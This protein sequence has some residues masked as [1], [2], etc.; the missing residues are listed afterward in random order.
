MRPLERIQLLVGIAVLAT[1]VGCGGG[2]SS[3]GA[4]TA[5][6][7]A[8]AKAAKLKREEEIVARIPGGPDP[9]AV[10]LLNRV[11]GFGML[12]VDLAHKTLYRFGEDVRGSG[13]THCY[14][15]CTKVWYPKAS[16]EPPASGS[17]GL[18]ES[19]FGTITRKEGY[20][21]ATFDGWP[22]YTYIKEK[23]RASKGIGLQAFGGTWYA[24]RANGESVN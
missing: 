13:K 1:L 22:L 17:R 5:K 11:P 10:V 4:T 7:S 15:A 14:G 20:R 2:G 12:L 21:Q 19:K 9:Q 16:Y 8:A 18:D 3:G 24:L 6:E 23:G